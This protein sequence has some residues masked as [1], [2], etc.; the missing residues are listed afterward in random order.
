MPNDIGL[1]RLADKADL[2]RDDVGVACVPDD[3]VGN[4]A[5]D[6][7]DCWISGWGVTFCE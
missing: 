7:A 5:N 2:S 6:S 1:M 3:S 4:F